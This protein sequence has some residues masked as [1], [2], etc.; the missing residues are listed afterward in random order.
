MTARARIVSV[1]ALAIQLAPL[2]LHASVQQRAAPD[3]VR[4]DSTRQPSAPRPGVEVSGY[5]QVFSKSRRD[6][7][8]DGAM[9]PHLFRVQRA[10]IGFKGD[11]TRRVAYEV[12]I[13]PRSPEVAGFLRDAFVSLDYLPRHEIRVG[14]QKTLFGYENPT[15]SSRLFVV[16]RA[17]ISDNLARGVNL[18]DIGVS[19]LGSIRLSERFR[20]EDALSVVNGA[21]MNVQADD[22]PRKNVWGRL[23]GRYRKDDF[24]LRFGVSAGSGDRAEVDSGPTPVLTYVLDFTRLGVDVV[25]DHP[26][27]FLAAEYVK[28]EDTGP[29]SLPDVGGGASGYYAILVGKTR[30]KAGP[31]IRYDAMEAFTRWTLGGYAGLPS[32]AVSLL[33]NYER[34][35]DEA[36]RHDDRIYL[37]LQV[38]F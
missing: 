31:L 9:D 33:L 5:I 12:E 14:Q 18:R 27:L 19:V 30:W 6:A 10:R 1:A 23:G 20:I 3:S 13:D 34:Y 24:T 32:D 11:V 26:K 7:S 25:V 36:G 22:T 8:G 35:Q 15:S 2:A 37:R 17:E 21:G 16:N 28:G 38:R 4:T 29:P